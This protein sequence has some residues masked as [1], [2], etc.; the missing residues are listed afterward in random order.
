MGKPNKP[1]YEL[2]KTLKKQIN[3]NITDCAGNEDIL[4]VGGGDTA[5]E[6]AYFIYKENRVTLSYRKSEITRANPKNTKNLLNVAKDGDIELKLGIDIVSVE[7]ENGKCKVI[8]ADNTVGIYDRIIY[9][10]G[11]ST[12][13]EFLSN[14]PILVDE[15]GKPIVNE[16]NL[17]SKGIYL[18]G[19]I[20]GS[21]GGS[22]ALALNHGYDIIQDILKKSCEKW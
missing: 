2:P 4:V 13:K 9:G 8:F 18:A 16:N 6:F 1:D 14:S 20:A 22:I 5:C 17:N 7:D 15:K 21:M 12:P 10:L 19:D 11:G 3:H